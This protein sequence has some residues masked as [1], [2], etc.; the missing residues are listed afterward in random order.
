M[1]TQF[2]IKRT[3]VV[4]ISVFAILFVVEILKGHSLMDSLLFSLLW[5]ALS[6]ATFIAT[7][8]YYSRK[9]VDCALCQDTKN[10]ND[11]TSKN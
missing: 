2:W 3:L 7:R 9:G 4:F 6:T 5:S 1:G 11:T 10:N 8:L